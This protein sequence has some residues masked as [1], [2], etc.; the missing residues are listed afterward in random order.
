VEAAQ[1]AL[2]PRAELVEEVERVLHREVREAGL[3]DD[4]AGGRRGVAESHLVPADGQLPG[5]GQGAGEQAEVIRNL[6]G[7]EE[8]G[9]ITLPPAAIP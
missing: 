9:H 8:A 1:A 5:D 3:G 4:L 7:E 2:A 6:D